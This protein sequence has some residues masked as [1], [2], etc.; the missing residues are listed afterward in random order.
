MFKTI[1]MNPNVAIQSHIFF[2]PDP[3]GSGRVVINE[4]I[5]TFVHVALTR[6][7][8]PSRSSA[9]PMRAICNIPKIGTSIHAS[10][11]IQILEAVAHRADVGIVC[12]RSS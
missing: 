11:F 9:N 3:E 6:T 4:R 2:E 7:W 5:T 1:A 12:V 8:I 10:K